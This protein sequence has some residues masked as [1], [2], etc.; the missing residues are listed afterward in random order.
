ME[1]LEEENPDP[2]SPSSENKGTVIEQL[3]RLLVSSKLNVLLVFVPFG[4]MAGY[5]KWSNLASFFL[6][7]LALIPLAAM[8]GDFTEDIAKRS[9]EAIGALINVSFGNAT[10]MIISIFAMKAGLFNIIKQ[11]LVGSVLGNMLLVLGCSFLAGGLRSSQTKFN[12][13]AANIYCSLLLLAIMSFI[14]PTA[15]VQLHGSVKDILMVSRQIAIVTFLTYCAYIAFQLVTHKSLFDGIGDSDKDDKNEEKKEGDEDDDDDDEP[16][17]S[18]LFAI[19]G[20]GIVAVL[21]SIGSDYIVDNIEGAAR[22]WGVSKHFMSVILLP[23]IGNAAEH[24]SAVTLAYRGRMDLALGIAIGS[25]IQISSFVV[26][27]MVLVAWVM[28][29]PLDMNFHPFSTTILFASVLI[30]NSLV[31]DGKSHWLEGLM[32]ISAYLMLI[33]VFVYAPDGVD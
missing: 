13:T 9:N 11:S 20:I 30:V 24:A 2:Q 16:E 32:L 27:L 5:F 12:K 26:P 18:F 14:I 29:L 4:L 19:V 7:G 22:E 15:F 33:I 31:V 28:G 8:L 21:I 6:N 3:R 17:F 23:I 10:E 1:R 25:S